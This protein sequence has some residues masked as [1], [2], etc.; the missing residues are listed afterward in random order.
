MRI[1][2]DGSGDDSGAAGAG[3]GIGVAI[4]VLF[5]FGIGYALYRCKYYSKPSR[6]PQPPARKQQLS[7]PSASGGGPQRMVVQVAMT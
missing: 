5:A 7:S 2:S 3:I 6:F 1:D 4:G